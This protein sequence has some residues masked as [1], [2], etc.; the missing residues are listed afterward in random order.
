MVMVTVM[1]V[2]TARMLTIWTR[3]MMTKTASV[4]YAMA[5]VS[6]AAVQVDVLWD[7]PAADCLS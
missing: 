5:V 7:R 1:R 3:L 4:I 2:T 6:Y